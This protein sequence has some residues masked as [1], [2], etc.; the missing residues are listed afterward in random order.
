MNQ[1]H[2]FW[3]QIFL[4]LFEWNTFFFFVRLHLIIS[5]NKIF[6][7][8]MKLSGRIPD[9]R[10]RLAT[11]FTA[12]RE[13]LLWCMLC[14]NIC[15]SLRR[16]QNKNRLTFL[17]WKFGTWKRD[18]LESL[19]NE[20]ACRIADTCFN[21]YKASFQ[22]LYVRT[23]WIINNLQFYFQ[24]LIRCVPCDLFSLWCDN[25]SGFLSYLFIYIFFKQN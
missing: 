8:W 17:Y 23:I 18:W 12:S 6:L 3:N 20:C 9:Q 22:L 14:D 19:T 25:S 4:Y 15:S 21:N 11:N 10:S 5:I 2:V 24:K 13:D 16:K 1:V 7:P